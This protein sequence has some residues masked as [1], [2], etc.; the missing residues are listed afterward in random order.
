[1]NDSSDILN[2]YFQNTY[3]EEARDLLYSAVGLLVV[4]SHLEPIG[5]IV[6][7]I[8]LEGSIEK[9]TIVDGV[10]NTI[11]KGIEELIWSNRIKLG[12]DVTFRRKI[13]IL[14]SIFAL[15]KVE[16][17]SDFIHYLTGWLT[18]EEKLARVLASVRGEQYED[19][20]VDF[21]WVY[22]GSVERLKT[23][24]ETIKVENETLDM[25]MIRGIRENL[26]IFEEVFGVPSAVAALNE[27]NPIKGQAFDLYDLLFKEELR[28]VEKVEEIAYA[29]LWLSLIS[30]DGYKDPMAVLLNRSKDL[31]YEIQEQK[32]F[33]SIVT[34]LLGLFIAKKDQK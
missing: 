14:E 24:F 22:E 34:Q 15:T 29:Y 18:P 8:T 19:F 17:P 33:D 12:V 30:S 1:M 25:E 5:D 10:R 13:H 32:S 2:V 6:D 7:L 26:R 27:L 4:F 11:E 9:D 16:D 3:T 20:L 28:E 23:Y 31:F 21:V